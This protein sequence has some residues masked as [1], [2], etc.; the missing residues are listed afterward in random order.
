MDED[1]LDICS[2]PGQVDHVRDNVLSLKPGDRF[3]WDDPL[4][5]DSQVLTVVS[6]PMN[7]FGSVSIEVAEWDFDF[8]A[9]SS[10]MVEVVSDP[11]G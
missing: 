8:E 1:G 7:H 11:H 5:Q 6:G 10:C 2:D 9:T 4:S 3:I